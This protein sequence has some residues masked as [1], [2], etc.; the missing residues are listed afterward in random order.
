M[1]FG[2]DLDSSTRVAY[3]V[4]L[5]TLPCRD[6]CLHARGVA[7]MRESRHVPP[8]GGG[9]VGPTIRTSG[10]SCSISRLFSL[11]PVGR[12]QLT[13]VQRTCC[14]FCYP[15]QIHNFIPPKSFPFF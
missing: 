11:L 4:G 14:D 13:A 5:R 2:W 12:A 9:D 15:K 3:K 7:K 8:R 1:V 6:E 10:I